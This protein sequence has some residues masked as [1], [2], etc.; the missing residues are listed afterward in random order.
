MHVSAVGVNHS[1]APIV[2]RE[3][4]TITSD[5]LADSLRLLGRYVTHGIILST[6]NRTEVYAVDSRPS[7]Q[8]SIDFLKAWAGIPDADLL[9]YIYSYRDESTF[10]H[11]FRVAGGLDSMIVGE[12]EVLGQVKQAL[13]AAE[14]AEMVNL[15]LRNLFRDAIRT[16][17]RVRKETGIS[18]NALS[19]S[20]VA[21]TVATGIVGGLAGR[22]IL[23]IGA[24]KAGRLVASAAS[25]KGGSQIVIYN[26]S[27]QRA[28][29]LAEKLGTGVVASGTLPEEL[30][31]ADIA[32]S[33]TAAPHL[34]LKV[35]QMAEV[36]KARPDRP[37]VIID[38]A[39]PRD[40]APE[41]KQLGNV[42]LY[43]IDDLTEVGD[44]NRSQRERECHE[45]MKIIQG[46]VARFT[47]WWQSLEVRPTISALVKK[48]DDIRRTQLAMTLGKL[49]ELNDEQQN[50]VEAMTEAIVTKVLNEPIQYLK[51]NAGDKGGYAEM[52]S[53]LFRLS[54]SNQ[55][56]E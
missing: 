31:A 19:I 4:L 22:R 12:F 49:P 25:K 28:L 5:R 18:K 6:C 24:G 10:D 11:L 14:K 17:R 26:R 7:E 42:F 29:A 50:S 37:L 30:T 32:I 46:E 13:E 38:I 27:R 23:V 15:P 33:C 8:A 53:R 56:D 40:V 1:T 54:G 41:V 44:W 9:P 3:K 39:V 21:V 52:V 20:S 55:Y 48:A 43:N 36:M 45:A 35:D 2:L 16:G 47:T 51:R 34:V